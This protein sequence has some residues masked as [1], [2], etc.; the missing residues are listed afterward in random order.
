MSVDN[1]NSGNIDND[2]TKNWQN[3]ESTLYTYIR[4]SKPGK[5]RWSCL[6]KVPD[7]ESKFQFLALGKTVEFIAK[8]DT[9]KEYGLSEITV[10]QAGY[11]RIDLTG[12]AKTGKEFGLV[13][14]LK[15]SGSAVD[16]NISFVKNN[17]DNFFYW[18]RR[19]PSIHLGYDIPVNNVE[20]F[21]NEVL[22]P[23]N[24]DVVGSFFMANGFREGYFGFQVNS[25]TERRI[26][27]SVWSPFQTDN[28][29]EIPE[30]QKIKLKRKGSDVYVGEFGNEGS[31][32]QSYLRYNWK[33]GAKYKFLLRATPIG[34]NFTDYT[35]YFFAPEEN[36]W[37]L[38]AS[39]S[40][41]KTNSFLQSLHSFVENF[42]P[43][44]GNITRSAQFSNQWAVDINKKWHQVTSARLS[45]DNTAATGF[46]KDFKGGSNQSYFYLQHCGFFSD[47]TAL[48]AE[49]HTSST[50]EA[51]AISLNDLP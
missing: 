11:I 40:R 50:S 4:L 8:G 51:P 45:G 33:S 7:G 18:G 17:T 5:L 12:I 23:Q 29:N 24:H 32:G 25:P 19:G 43:N 37:R 39:F 21:Y 14:G 16:A 46:R 35:A 26:L 31:G 20:W 36:K 49:F 13:T 22:V 10:Q 30:D 48:G 2:G 44:T 6:A 9:L 42:N 38:I 3:A 1:I 28:P 47:F 41:P 15:V 27:F 34:N